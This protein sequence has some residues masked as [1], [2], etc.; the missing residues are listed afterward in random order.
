[1]KIMHL[2]IL[3]VVVVGL[4]VTGGLGVLW[5]LNLSGEPH[6]VIANNTSLINEGFRQVV[7]SSQ[8]DRFTLAEANSVVAVTLGQ[9]NTS[10]QD[11][12]VYYVKGL[13]VN[14]SGYA[15]RWILGIREGR[16]TTL[17]TYDRTGAGIISGPWDKLPDQ[18]IDLAGIVSPADVMKIVHSGNQTLTGDAELEISQGIYTVTGPAGSHPRE[19]R[20]NATTGDVI[21]THD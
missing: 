5:L 15:E 19:Y 11:Y 20:I 1:M 6:T 18:E 10:Q 9:A 2:A 12:P 16:N 7:T 17:M 14:N 13:N 4:T 8:D 3:V 21:A